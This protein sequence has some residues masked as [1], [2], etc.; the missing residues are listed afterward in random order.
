[1][2][3]FVQKKKQYIKSSIINLTYIVFDLL[4]YK[5]FYYSINQNILYV[6]K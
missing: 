1:M 5:K 3:T 2:Y 6:C 4:I